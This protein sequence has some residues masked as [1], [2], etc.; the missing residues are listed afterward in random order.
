MNNSQA[1]VNWPKLLLLLFFCYFPTRIIIQFTLN[2]LKKHYHREITVFLLKKMVAF[3]AKNKEIMV[4]KKAE[5]VF[6]LNDLVPQFS[7]QFLELPV[8]LFN[9]SI[10]IFLETLSLFFLI[11]SRSLH[12]ITPL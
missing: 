6:V 1:Y 9:V 3:A 11:K 8:N 10:D 5:K 12:E 4:K 2:Y 7:Q